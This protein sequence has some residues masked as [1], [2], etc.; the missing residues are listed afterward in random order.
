[1][2]VLLCDSNCELWY[3]RAR[4]LGLEVIRMPY[5]IDNEEYY[6]DLGEKTDFRDFYDR[7]RKGSVPNTSALNPENYKE[8]HEP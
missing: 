3:T 1:M 2:S 6:Y 4:E 5:T 8:I 7:V